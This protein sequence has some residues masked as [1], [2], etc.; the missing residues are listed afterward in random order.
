MGGNKRKAN[1]AKPTASSMSIVEKLGI[2]RSLNCGFSESDLSNCLRQSG[3]RVDVAAERLVTGQYR[4]MKKATSNN[5]FFNAV[6]KPK[7]TM[8]TET[9]HSNNATATP[10][11][12]T[13]TQQN[14]SVMTPSSSTNVLRHSS[15]EDHVT[16]LV[17]NKQ[18]HT[19][20][21]PLSSSSNL[22]T[23][24]STTPAAKASKG[25]EGRIEMDYGDW[26]LCQRWVGD[27][28]NL[29]RGGACD[30]LE[31]F[32]VLVEASASP[33]TSSNSSVQKGIRF[34]SESRRMDGSLPRHLAFLGP[35]LRNQL[36]RVKATAL[37][38]E[39][40]LPIGAQVALS[41]T[42]WIV[43][44]GRFFAVF[45]DGKSSYVPSY[46]K[47]FFATVAAKAKATN[48]NG[49]PKAG[50]PLES[51]RN[52]AFAMLQWAQYGKLPSTSTTSNDDDGK[53]KDDGVESNSD[54]DEGDIDN[55]T[56]AVRTSA[57]DEEATIPDWARDLHSSNNSGNRN[58]GNGTEM[59]MDTPIGFKKG[60]KL[61][62]YQKRSLY[63]MTQREKLFGSGR[64][65][66][67][68][69]LH[70]LAT[71][72]TKILNTGRKD[73]DD[74][75]VLGSRKA[76]SCDCGPVIVDTNSMDAPPASKVF[77]K[78]I[79]CIDD[80]SPEDRDLDHPLWER[81][82]L[83]NDKRSKALS[84]YVQPSFRNAAAEAPPPPLPCR[85]GILADSM[86]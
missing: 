62:P 28:L 81:R 13:G 2:L 60:V 6:S 21:A 80:D 45:D 44:L 71:E 26:L 20:R 30:Y 23:P 16:P 78:D 55:E 39:R 9:S 7:S 84:F 34:R 32:H 75:R 24:K 15:S 17:S 27:G 83:C 14:H 72:S 48:A 74:V 38:E 29:Q 11:Q 36:I 54:I 50:S 5:R 43:D 37:M 46:S 3:Y 25:G 64:N 59:E 4:P 76:I 82:F 19:P 8:H 33:T 63:W 66:L 73:D 53:E 56:S 85:G 69:L 47:Q 77:A 61:R 40:R 67:V 18:N 1:G 41:L 49:S 65:E 22:I 10:Q 35:L 52:A 12:T 86:G 68:Q 58:S 70:E 57:E 51:C 42:I 79:I 31:E